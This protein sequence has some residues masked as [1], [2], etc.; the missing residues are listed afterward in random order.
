[1]NLNH[2]DCVE[3]KCFVTN[4]NPPTVKQ[5]QWKIEQFYVIID[6][7]KSIEH[8]IQGL[9][10]RICVLRQGNSVPVSFGERVYKFTIIICFGSMKGHLNP[11][12]PSLMHESLPFFA[13]PIPSRSEI[14]S[15]QFSY[16]HVS[17]FDVQTNVLRYMLQYHMGS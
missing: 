1:M 3:P 5:F 14:K 2:I 8:N 15:A 11:L 9:K 7:V 12:F 10:W 13:K 4:H 6:P 16:T 17:Y